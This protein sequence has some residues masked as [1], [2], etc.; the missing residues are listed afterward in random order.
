MLC[1]LQQERPLY[2]SILLHMG[3]FTVVMTVVGTFESLTSLLMRKEVGVFHLFVLFYLMICNMDLFCF[4]DYHWWWRSFLTSGFTAIYLFIYCIHYLVSKLEIHGS[5]SYFLY[6]GY[7]FIMVF[8]FF[9]LTGKSN[10]M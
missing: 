1:W 10:V 5:A 7:T 6:L 3:F 9:L 8:L 4:K 2:Y